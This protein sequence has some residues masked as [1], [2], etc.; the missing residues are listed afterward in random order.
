MKRWLLRIAVI[1]SALAVLASG[2]WWG[3]QT[4]WS[5]DQFP[6]AVK[7]G[8]E[9]EDFS[10]AERLKRWGTDTEMWRRE[11][12]GKQVY[13]TIQNDDIPRLRELCQVGL[14]M[15]PGGIDRYTPLH[16]AVSYSKPEAVKVLLAAGARVNARDGAGSTPL[17]Y[18][19]MADPQI[20]TALIDAGAE[21]N[22]TDNRGY[23]PLDVA[24][25]VQELTEGSPLRGVYPGIPLLK[26]AGARANKTWLYNVPDFDPGT[27]FPAA[28][29]PPADAARG[30]RE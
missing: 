28:E 12:S 8:I 17:H 1:L 18:A 6:A 2:G 20:V 15:D 9:T 24:F 27:L 7:E 5:S 29:P 23:T 19:Y 14:P 26:A 16:F 30:S 21:V 13:E 4:F 10:T 3:W 22:A 25:S 11:D